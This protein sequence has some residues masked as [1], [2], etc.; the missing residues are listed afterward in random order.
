MVDYFHAFNKLREAWVAFVAQ[1]ISD[2]QLPWTFRADSSN[3]AVGTMLH[4][5][6]TLSGGTGRFEPVGFASRKFSETAGN[7]DPYKEEAF[8]CYFGADHLAYYLRGTAFILET[9]HRSS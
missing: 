6:R 3:I 2:Y 7:W 1:P 5:I 9:D 8:A 4:Q